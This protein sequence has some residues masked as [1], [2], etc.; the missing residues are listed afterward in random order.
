VFEF[1]LELFEIR[2]N[3]KFKT[4]MKKKIKRKGFADRGLNPSARLP[5]QRLSRSSHPRGSGTPAGRIRS[6]HLHACTGAM[7]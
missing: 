3:L 6:A 2:L 4:E 5:A 1:E 7:A